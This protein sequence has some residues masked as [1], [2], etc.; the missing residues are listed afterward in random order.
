M[1]TA[2]EAD[3]THPELRDRAR[4]VDDAV[5]PA[6]RPH[7]EGRRRRR[8]GRAPDTDPY[9]ARVGAHQ[10]RS[11]AALMLSRLYDDPAHMDRVIA[12][13]IDHVETLRQRRS[14]KEQLVTMHSQH[15]SQRRRRRPHADDQWTDPAG[16]RFHLRDRDGSTSSARSRAATPRRR[17]PPRCSA[18]TSTKSNA[19]A[20]CSPSSPTRCTRT[21]WARCTAASSP[22]SSTA[23]WVARCSRCCPPAP[24][25]TTLELKT[26]YVRPIVQTTGV[27][28]AEGR[29]VHLGGRVA[30]T[31]ATRHRRPTARCTR[32]RPRRA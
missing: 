19:A 2:I 7:R 27:V 6:H 15:L 18:C 29:V 26:N 4:A 28:R 8:H 21:R 1:N 9:D 30:T 13:L 11:K 23:R 14:P 10:R 32:T 20:S 31:E 17:P 3:D 5:A 16:A 12:H 25:Y 24:R 22:R